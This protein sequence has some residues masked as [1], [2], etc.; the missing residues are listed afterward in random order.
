MTTK[1]DNLNGLLTNTV[2]MGFISD[3]GYHSVEDIQ[4]IIGIMEG[5]GIT[6]ADWDVKD[7]LRAIQTAFP[8]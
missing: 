8:D 3:Q 6:G 5:Q 2:L 4:Y 1:E 7:I